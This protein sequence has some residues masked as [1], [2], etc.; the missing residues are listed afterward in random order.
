MA[1]YF[2]K[3]S[4]LSKTDHVFIFFFFLG[5]LYIAGILFRFLQFKALLAIFLVL[6][7]LLFVFL[8]H[9]GMKGSVYQMAMVHIPKYYN[10]NGSRISSEPLISKVY[11]RKVD[12]KKYISSRTNGNLFISGRSGSGK[13]TLM[14]YIINLF[15]E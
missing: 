8:E 15:S 7:A 12:F 13:S 10:S 9:R 11:K 2:S 1:R 5:A 4:K 14:R 3:F 6:Y